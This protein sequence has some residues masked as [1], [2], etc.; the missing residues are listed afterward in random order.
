MAQVI[1]RRPVKAE[2]WVQFE[3]IPSRL[4]GGQ[5]VEI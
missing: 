2:A 5:N 4:C 3:D 1:C